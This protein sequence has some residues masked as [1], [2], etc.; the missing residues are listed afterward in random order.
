[1]AVSF[2]GGGHQ[3]TR[4]KLPTCCKTLDKLY[5][6]MLYKIYLAWAGLELTL[7][8]IGTDCIDSCTTIRPRLPL[9]D[10][11]YMWGIVINF[12]CSGS[13]SILHFN[14]FSDSQTSRT[15]LCR[16]IPYMFLENV[17]FVLILDGNRCWI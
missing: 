16:D 17:C 15:K 8:V 12:L 2:I 7:V 14:F 1:M 9:L 10:Q 13:V 11:R 3:S 5:H 4:R 6:I